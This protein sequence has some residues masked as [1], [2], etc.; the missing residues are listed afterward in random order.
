MQMQLHLPDPGI[1]LRTSLLFADRANHCTKKSI[2]ME[3]CNE[4]VKS[5]ITLFD[6]YLSYFKYNLNYEDLALNIFNI[7]EVLQD[8][9]TCRVEM[10]T[11]Q[12]WRQ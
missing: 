8:K 11:F 3:P 2:I 9:G 4:Q 10:P 5:Y 1:K 7:F 12:L 6:W